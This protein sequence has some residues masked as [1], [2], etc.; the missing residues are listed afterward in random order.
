MD[1]PRARSEVRHLERT[2]NYLKPGAVDAALRTWREYVHRPRR[3]LWRDHEHG[4]VY[5]SY[6]CANPFEARELLDTV[7]GAMSPRSARELRKVVGRADAV[8]DRSAS[9]DGTRYFGSM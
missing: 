6:C 1:C 8:W 2:R 5:W 4:N 9:Y 7:L 3:E